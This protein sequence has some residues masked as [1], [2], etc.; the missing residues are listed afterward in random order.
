MVGQ[1][2]P[3]A[4]T[5]ASMRALNQRLV[6]D[7]LR[8][9]GEATRPQIA[10]DTGLSKPTVGQALL[11]LEQ[12]GLV[13]AIGRSSAR[14]GRA[15]G[16]LPDGSGRGSH[17]RCRRR[18]ARDPRRGR[19]PGRCDRRPSRTAEPQP[20]GGHVAADN[21]GIRRTCHR[22]GR[23]GPARHRGDCPRDAGHPGR[24]QRHGAPGAESARLG[25]PWLVARVGVDARSGWLGS[26][27]GKRRQSVCGR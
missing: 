3:Q 25:T 23:A 12:H 15:G 1:A 21:A 7:R 24:G 2:A 19:R 16:H 11:D 9:H 10:G 18:Q 4:G 20:V 13:R 6:L 26:D 5:P 17:R 22:G 14:P 8:G 27:R